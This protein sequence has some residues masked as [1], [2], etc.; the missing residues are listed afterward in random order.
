M[1]EKISYK[2][3]VLQGV[4]SG[5]VFGGALGWMRQ[6]LWVGLLS[7]AAFGL[8]MAVVLRKQWGSKAFRGLDRGQRRTVRRAM[9]RGEAVDDP[10]LARPLLEAVDGVLGTPFPVVLYRVVYALPGALALFL[11]AL[12]VPD[13]GWSAVVS[14]LPLLLI[15]GVLLFVLLPIVRRQRGRVARA[16]ELTLARFPHPDAGVR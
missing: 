14:G 10:R 8:V 11:V 7:G 4:V 3:V 12:N 6:N 9:R 2:Q 16:A 15:S 13:D 1:A 5:A